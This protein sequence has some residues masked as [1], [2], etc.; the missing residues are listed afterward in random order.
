MKSPLKYLLIILFSMTL[1]AC[2]SSDDDDDDTTTTT[3][4]TTGS[5][6][7]ATISSSN[8]RSLGIAATEGVK[9]AVSSASAPLR[10][11][12]S[13][14]IIQSH[15]SK[16]VAQPFDA[17]EACTG[18]GTASGDISDDGL[19][20]ELVY[21]QCDIS[22]AVIDGTL[23]SLTSTSGNVTT[24]T[25]TWDFIYTFQGMTESYNYSSVCTTDA[26]TFA[27][28]DCS[29]DSSI[30]GIDDR[31][32]NVSDSSVSGDSSSGYTVSATV[33]DPDYGTFSIETTSPILLNCDNGQPSSGEIVFSDS[34]GVSVTVTFN[35][36]N[37]FT[38]AYSGGSEM[39][40]WSS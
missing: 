8:E 4:T 23:A 19:D 32:Y 11:T 34:T 2:S 33:S 26:T 14:A 20:F 15:A 37:S 29:Y 24:T 6:G 13:R 12:S 7:E 18:G 35:D 10:G 21:D 16:L 31:T 40:T 3:T 1:F 28:I 38:V 30:D 17:S 9:A 5:T 39:Y 27:V 36:C 25:L 22:G